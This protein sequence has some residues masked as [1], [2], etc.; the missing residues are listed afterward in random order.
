[1][2][3]AREIAQLSVRSS[4]QSQYYAKYYSNKLRNI[5]QYVFSLTRLNLIIVFLRKK[6]RWLVACASS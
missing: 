1:M 4:W 2:N 3:L 5:A 6:V